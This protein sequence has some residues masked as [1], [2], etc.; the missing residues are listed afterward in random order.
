MVAVPADIPETTPEEDPI[1]A[2][3]VFVLVQTPPL[4]PSLNAVVSPAHTFG[5]PVMVVGSG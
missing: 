1:M 5:E 3:A 2:I 4:V